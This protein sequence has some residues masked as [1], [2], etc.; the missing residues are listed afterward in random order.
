MNFGYR[1]DLVKDHKAR[2]IA[3]LHSKGKHATFCKAAPNLK[4]AAPTL[5]IL[6]DK[7][8]S[9][10]GVYLAAQN[11]PRGTCT[12]R[13]GKRACDIIQVQI[14][15]A[16][17]KDKFEYLSHAILYGQGRTIAQMLDGR[18]ND[19]NSDGC[20][21]AA[22]AQAANTVGLVR[23]VDDKDNDNSDDIAVVWGA[24]GVPKEVLVLAKGHIVKEIAQA[25]TFEDVRD[26]LMADHPVTV[27]S[28]VGF[29]GNRGFN[30]DQDGVARRG[31]TWPHQMIFTGYC[32]NLNGRGE[33]LLVDQSWGP[34]QPQG[35][36]GPYPIPS[37]SFW[38]LR[39]DAESMIAE[40]DTWIYS[41]F[42]GWVTPVPDTP[43]PTPAPAVSTVEAVLAKIMTLFTTY[44][45]SVE[46]LIPLVVAVV[47]SPSLANDLA[48]FHGIVAALQTAQTTK[49][50]VGF[51]LD[52]ATLASIFQ[53]ALQILTEVQALIAAQA[54]VKVGDAAPVVP[55]IDDVNSAV[56]VLTSAVAARAVATTAVVPAQLAA[57]AA[58]TALTTAQAAVTTAS[59]AVT[60]AL[61]ALEATEVAYVAGN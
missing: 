12:S 34:N 33:A 44:G 25:Q 56:T 59:Q 57:T 52:P 20:T 26:A 9:I 21:G 7:V 39:P 11:Q 29:E 47:Q 50:K 40:G 48:L 36:L 10:L 19:P 38:V 5:K 3:H 17:L 23:N 27:A 24:Y 42:E 14:L 58:A 6:H 32:P 41:G 46:S 31:N 53:I 43:V 4:G 16:A 55:T 2:L 18:P 8:K 49:K 22:I 1:P 45:A 30:R 61:A 37:Y 28:T 35:P 60:D 54:A 15:G 51:T 13:G